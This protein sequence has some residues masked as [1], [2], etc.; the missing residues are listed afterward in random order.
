MYYQY[1]KVVINK[2]QCKLCGDIIE[3][4]SGHDFKTC[5]CGEI[6]VDGGRQYIR[7][8]AKNLDNIVELSVERY[9]N[10]EEIL[11]KITRLEDDL[12][13]TKSSPSSPSS[14]SSQSYYEEQLVKAKTFLQQLK[15]NTLPTLV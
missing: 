14:P 9:F 5:K 4:K 10:E 1:T 6:S 12:L 7:R 13:M 2:A 15:D 8:A 11:A 3:S